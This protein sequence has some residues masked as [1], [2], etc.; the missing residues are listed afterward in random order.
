MNAPDRSPTKSGLLG[1]IYCVPQIHQFSFPTVRNYLRAYYF[2]TFLFPQ[3]T[4][5]NSTQ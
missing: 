3:V 4:F 2:T 5:I 1:M